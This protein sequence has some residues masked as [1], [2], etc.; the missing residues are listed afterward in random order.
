ML[1][2]R[3]RPVIEATL[4]LVGERIP[5]IAQ[6]FYRNLFDAHPELLDGTFNRGNQ[7]RGEQQQALAGSVAAFASTL[8][9][10]PEHDDVGI[11]DVL[12]LSLPYGDVV[13]DDAG[14]PVVFVSAGIGI[15]PWP[16]CC[17]TW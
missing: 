4:P 14:R 1:S 13:L 17:R 9:A 5:E 3:N 10:T 8:V 11:D 6:R 2:D 12:T 16:A 7:A 15:S